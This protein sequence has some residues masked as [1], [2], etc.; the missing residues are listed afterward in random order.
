MVRFFFDSKLFNS[1][2]RPAVNVEL[3]VSRVGGAAQTKA[4][5]KVTRA[6]RLELTQYHDLLAFSQF[7]TELD[8]LSQK[9]LARG[10]MIVELL[11]QKQFSTY[12]FVDQVLMLFLLRENFLDTLKAKKVTDF[13]LQYVSY[14]KSVY[15]DVYED[16]LVTKDLS[17]TIEDQLRH[18]AREL[19]TIVVV[20]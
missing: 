12:S 11:Q 16:I 17:T 13:A 9:R 15:K 4:M 2:I 18:I 10:A 14:V 20:K 8:P 5:K 7:G 1:G 6:L 3:S 19:L